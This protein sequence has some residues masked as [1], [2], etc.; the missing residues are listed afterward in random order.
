M[1]SSKSNPVIF[2]VYKSTNTKRSPLGTQLIFASK[3]F[4]V[5]SYFFGFRTKCIYINSGCIASLVLTV[6]FG[7]G[8]LGEHIALAV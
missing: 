6:S 7:F 2:A 3:V 1:F 8:H 5:K 4:L